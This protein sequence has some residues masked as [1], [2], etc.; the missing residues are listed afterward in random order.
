[1]GREESRQFYRTRALVIERVNA[2]VKGEKKQRKV[3][4]RGVARGR[5]WWLLVGLVTNLLSFGAW[6]SKR[7]PRPNHH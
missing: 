2:V 6:S 5:G 4:V 3:P 7:S 1:M